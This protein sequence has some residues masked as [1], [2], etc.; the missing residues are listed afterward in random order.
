MNSITRERGEQYRY[1]FGH[2]TNPCRPVH[3]LSSPSTAAAVTSFL[4]W[5]HH[6]RQGS[7]IPSHCLNDSCQEERLNPH[8]MW[9][10]GE[11]IEF[12]VL[13]P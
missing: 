4:R 8:R 10:E 6:M 3:A 11:T 7:Q 2:V 1:A 5:Q 13:S 12:I 9:Y